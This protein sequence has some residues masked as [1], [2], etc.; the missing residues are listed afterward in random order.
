MHH[1]ALISVEVKDRGIE[2]SLRRFKKLCDSFGILRE[3]RKRK[4]Y[5]KPSVR[6]K[7][8]FEASQ[9]RKRKTVA[10]NTFAR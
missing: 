7:E 4:E 5:K 8:K 6:L 10:R 3:Y 2:R 9:K 1:K